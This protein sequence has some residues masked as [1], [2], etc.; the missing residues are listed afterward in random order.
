[1]NRG[2]TPEQLAVLADDIADMAD[3]FVN[4][5]DAKSLRNMATNLAR[6][7]RLHVAAPLSA[8]RGHHMSDRRHAER[9]RKNV[10]PCHCGHY[11]SQHEKIWDGEA[12]VYFWFCHGC[13]REYKTYPATHHAPTGGTT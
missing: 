3:D 2:M 9:R 4:A 13:E 6:M 11:P 10:A 5:S 8:D 7:I 12:G 1:M